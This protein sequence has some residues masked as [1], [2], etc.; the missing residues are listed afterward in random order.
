MVTK[1]ALIKIQITV[2]KIKNLR[3]QV[4]KNFPSGINFF[5]TNRRNRS[6]RYHNNHNKAKA[7]NP[8]RD[9]HN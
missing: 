1:W 3:W 2:L 5:K 4:L 7:P 9:K 8:Y 6:R